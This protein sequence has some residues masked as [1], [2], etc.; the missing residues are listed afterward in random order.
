MRIGWP[1]TG[2]LKKTSETGALANGYTLSIL[3][4]S[5]QKYLISFANIS[6]GSIILMPDVE[7]PGDLYLG[8]VDRPYS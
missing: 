7:N 5:Y 2:D 8:E 6:E 1:D 3:A 4:S